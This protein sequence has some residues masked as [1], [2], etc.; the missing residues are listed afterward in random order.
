MPEIVVDVVTPND[1]ADDMTRKR[2]LYF[3][4]GAL[5]AWTF[6]RGGQIR[7]YGPE[8]PLER[9]TPVPDFPGSVDTR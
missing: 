7:F 6:D 8:G 4:C 9:S 1:S 5:E 2:T 3:E